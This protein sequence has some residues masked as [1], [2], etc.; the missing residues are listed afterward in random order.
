MSHWNYRI[1]KRYFE[2]KDDNGE[3]MMTSYLGIHSCYYLNDGKI[4]WSEKPEEITGDSIESL[5]WTLNK[6]LEAL[7]RDIIEDK[8][9]IK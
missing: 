6:M 5:K 7:D 4:G 9:T 3:P 8:E 2:D 1:V